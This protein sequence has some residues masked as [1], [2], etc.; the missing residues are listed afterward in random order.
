[1]N[2]SNTD[3]NTETLA[4][5]LQQHVAGFQGPVTLKKFKGGQSNPTYLLESGHGPWVLRRQP[6]GELLK[7]A[8]AVDREFRVLKALENTEVPVAQA[9]H[10]C[11]DRSVIGSMFYLMRFEEGE[12]FWN[13]ALPELESAKRPSYYQEL[14][15]ILAA[16]HSVNLNAVGL[17]DY[18]KPGNYFERQ[19]A[20]WTKQYQSSQ[21]EE[22]PGMAALMAW[23]PAHCP[24]EDGQLS[25]VH[26][27]YRLDNIMFKTGQPQGQAVLD[28]ELSTLGHPMA[29]LAYFCMCLR[30]P[31]SGF[32]PGLAGQNRGTLNIPSESELV[33]HYCAL[34]RIDAPKHW[35]FYLAFSFFRLAA[36]AQG[37]LKRAL[38]GNAAS[39]KALEV[40]RMTEPLAQMA[41]AVIDETHT[42]QI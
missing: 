10:L 2:P 13:P 8:H 11:E 24:A 18:G 30:L 17:G 20:V 4:A 3:I 33:A 41:L 34:R 38:S 12:I 21:T 40:G 22:L 27:D 42:Q 19:I 35:P 31:A 37:V 32:I 1:M 7:S 9:I 16:I 15:R 26:G 14:V 29:D 36:I 28:W 23:L 39:E 5:Y 25:L 6:P